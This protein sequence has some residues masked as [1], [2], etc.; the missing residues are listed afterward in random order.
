MSGGGSS[1]TITVPSGCTYT[2][3]TDVDGSVHSSPMVCDSSY[4]IPLGQ[5]LASAQQ[6]VDDV[7]WGNLTDWNWSSNPGDNAANALS[8]AIRAT[9]VQT[10]QNPCFYAAFYGGSAIAPT[11]VAF[12]GV[13]S[14][15]L[16]VFPA[17]SE[18]LAGSGPTITTATTWFQRTGAVGRKTLGAVAS[19]AGDAISSACK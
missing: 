10:L 9:G 13:T 6:A 12:G 16:A 11:I 1:L 19:L 5:L 14:D 8:A 2:S 15:T 4:T 7:E 3:W 18:T 17:F